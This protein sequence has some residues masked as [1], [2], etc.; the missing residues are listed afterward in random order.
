MKLLIAMYNDTAAPLCFDQIRKRPLRIL[1]V[2][3]SIPPMRCGVGDYSYSLAKALAAAGA[4]VGILTSAAAGNG[5]PAARL[6]IFPAMPAWTFR[7]LWRIARF[8]RQF[9][10]D[11]V[12]VQ[13]PTQGYGRGASALVPLV[14][15]LAGKKVFQTWHEIYGAGNAFVMGRGLLGFLLKAL[16]GYA[17]IVV[18]PNYRASLKGPFSW[19]VRHRELLFIPNASSIPVA[20]LSPERRDMLKAAYLDGQRRLIVFFGFL[21]PTKG[22]E[23]LFEIA[24]PERDRIVVAGAYNEADGY[25]R[26]LRERA[27]QPPWQ[28]K[29]TFTGFIRPDEAAELLSV[30][31][32]VV[33]PFR[34]G[35]GEWNT[36]IHGAILQGSFVLTTSH[37]SQGYDEQKNIY[38]S[39]IDDRQELTAALD[40]FVGRRRT[41]ES[42]TDKDEWQ[43]IAALHIARY[44][45]ALQKRASGGAK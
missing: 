19:A 17:I 45:E 1:I 21:H 27:S 26:D 41:F 12:H 35:G 9:A 22:V 6:E 16:V 14:A 37:L 40:K 44:S 36:S 7:N 5:V 11:V 8:V 18:R 24:D 34:G 29:V 28:G 4:H 20:A 32:A 39:R 2:T 43:K 25:H 31:D 30:A 3:G 15:A 10:P 38:F 13:F 42:E 23:L 33:L